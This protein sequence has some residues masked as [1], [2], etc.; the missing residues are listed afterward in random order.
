VEEKVVEIEEISCLCG[1][2]F[3]VFTVLPAG[4]SH[5]YECYKCPK[6]DV[7]NDRA[8]ESSRTRRTNCPLGRHA[9]VLADLEVRRSARDRINKALDLCL[10]LYVRMSCRVN[11]H[12]T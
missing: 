12:N 3:P 6:V 9:S 7:E 5:E 2:A 4:F 1:S 10:L 11:I 8:T